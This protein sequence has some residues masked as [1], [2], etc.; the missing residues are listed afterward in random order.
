MYKPIPSFVSFIDFMRYFIRLTFIT[1]FFLSDIFI[2]YYLLKQKKKKRVSF[3]LLKIETFF[4]I[5]VFFFCFFFL[6]VFCQFYSLETCINITNKKK[7][8]RKHFNIWHIII[9]VSFVFFLCLFYFLSSFFFM[10]GF[11][12]F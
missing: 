4:F 8:L 1:I 6:V 7:M 9:S 10:D 11:Q 5:S 3:I 12:S 2:H